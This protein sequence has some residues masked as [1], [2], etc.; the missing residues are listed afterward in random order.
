VVTGISASAF[1]ATEYAAFE[2]AMA[3]LVEATVRVTRVSETRRR[4]LV[5]GVAVAFDVF[6]DADSSM[7]VLKLA[8][9]HQDP[10]ALGV[11]LA[12]RLPNTA[13]SASGFIVIPVYA[14]PTPQPTYAS[15]P[16]PSPTPQPTRETTP[17]PTPQPTTQMPSSTPTQLPTFTPTVTAAPT[18]TSPGSKSSK[19]ALDGVVSVV[20]EHL[21]VVVTVAVLL[22]L[23]CIAACVLM[24]VFRKPGHNMRDSEC[25]APRLSEQHYAPRLSDAHNRASQQ[26][27]AP[28]EPAKVWSIDF[29]KKVWS[30]DF[31]ESRP[32][33]KKVIDFDE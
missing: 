21:V 1:G 9:L 27:A 25:I 28:A 29:D 24:R 23:I 31:E 13:V 7:L 11:Q 4:L 15:T 20:E 2:A 3:E 5:K 19:S 16:T 17:M 12:L 14:P 33:R 18:S 30:I 10:A 8:Q 26:A 22:F 32:N 6:A